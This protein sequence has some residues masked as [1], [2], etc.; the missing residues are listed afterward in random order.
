MSTLDKQ[1]SGNH[2]KRFKI[3]PVEF[4]VANNL[5]YI[6]GNVIKYICRH[7]FK[8][9]IEDINKIIHYCEILKEL[10][11]PETKRITLGDLVANG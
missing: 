10:T 9:G 6:E 1:V 7:S 8:N 11:Y 5:D 4:I 3:Q 2:Y